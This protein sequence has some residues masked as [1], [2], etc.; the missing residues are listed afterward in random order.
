[1]LEKARREHLRL[2][3]QLNIDNLFNFFVT[4]YHIQDYIKTSKAMTDVADL[5]SLLETPD[6]R[7]CRA[8]CNQGKHLELESKRGQTNP[9][10]HIWHGCFGGAPFNRMPFNSG[11]EWVVFVDNREIDVRRLA[12]RVLTM[13]EDFFYNHGL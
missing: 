4:A 8:I 12:D 5:N 11:P 9:R 3:T 6:M 10:S 13:W 1:M 2:S 7:A